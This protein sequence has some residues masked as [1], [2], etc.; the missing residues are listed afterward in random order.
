MSKYLDSSILAK[1]RPIISVC[2]LFLWLFTTKVYSKLKDTD[3]K[4]IHDTLLISKHLGRKITIDFILPPN[5]EKHPDRA[6]PVLFMNDGQDVE[7]LQM[8]AVLRQLY[9]QNHIRHFILVAV[10]CGDR[11]QEYG[12]A[13][14]LDYKQR[15]S[16]ATA[17]TQFVLEELMPYV[18]TKYRVLSGPKH[19]F[20]C[21]FSLGALSA[22]DMVWHHAAVF[23]KVGAFSGSFWWRQKAYDQQY[24]DERDRIAH[25]LVRESNQFASSN[26]PQ[27][28]F[29]TGTDDEKDDRNQNGIIDSIEDTLD[30]IAELEKKGYRWG[31]DIK[32]VEVKNGHHNPD[33]WAKIMPDFLTWAFG[34]E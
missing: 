9:Q 7:R 16:K 23:G 28:W 19:N 30:L 6:Y 4:N 25:R 22:F 11:M 14:Q 12:T 17:Y 26:S 2:L 20:W 8:Q 27:F 5:Y 13:S 3:I 21:G 15:G 32:Y 1:I 34:N 29:Q 10:H 24:K 31:H 18:Q 33:T